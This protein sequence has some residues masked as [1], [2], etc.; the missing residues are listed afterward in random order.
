VIGIDEVEEKWA[1]LQK[2]SPFHK[3]STLLYGRYMIEILNDD[4]MGAVLL[5]KL[6][7]KADES[8]INWEED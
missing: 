1:K 3:S 5:E 7:D 8:S 4:K 6:R 2:V